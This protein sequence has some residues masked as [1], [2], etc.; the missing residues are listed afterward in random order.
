MTNTNTDQLLKSGLVLSE[1]VLDLNHNLNVPWKLS[2][3]APWN[4]PSRLFQFPIEVSE[5]V[6]GQRRIGLMHPLL[7]DHPWV[8][9]VERELGFR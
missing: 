3:P 5:P 9:H 7:K 6:D 8:Q 4:L 1:Y 2:L